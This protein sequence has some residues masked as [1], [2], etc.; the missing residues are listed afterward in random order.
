MPSNN[1]AG[2]PELAD[3]SIGSLAINCIAD[4]A[5]KLVKSP[6]RDIIIFSSARIA[7]LFLKNSILL[8]FLPINEGSGLVTSSPTKASSHCGTAG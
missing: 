7:N 4:L 2:Y 1:I 8:M 5:K 6:G 3:I